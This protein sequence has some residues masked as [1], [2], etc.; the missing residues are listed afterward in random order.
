M[1]IIFTSCCCIGYHSLIGGQA[2]IEI[3]MNKRN[4]AFIDST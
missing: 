1:N 4:K 3:G 2:G